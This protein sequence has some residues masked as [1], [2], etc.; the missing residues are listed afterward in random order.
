LLILGSK[1]RQDRRHLV[2]THLV[3]IVVREARM[4]VAAVPLVRQRLI[5]VGGRAAALLRL[6][7]QRLVVLLR[8][9]ERVRADDRGPRIVA[10]AVTPRGLRRPRLADELRAVRSVLLF[11]RNW[12][13]AAEIAGMGPEILVFVEVLRRIEVDRERRHA[14]GRLTVAR[15]ADE[16]ADL[17]RC[18]VP[19][20]GENDRE[21]RAD[22]FLVGEVGRE[23]SGTAD[24]LEADVG[25]LLRAG[26]RRDDHRRGEHKRLEYRA[27]HGLSHTLVARREA[28]PTPW[29][30]RGHAILV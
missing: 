7:E 16:V 5:S 21:T 24:A 20:R 22:V 10:I 26:R 19:G 11:D 8:R 15:G 18:E 9:L 1:Q 17:D 14:L 4:R 23:R 6:G 29:G 13:V 30:R 25:R 2:V 3:P 12:A 27:A 28:L